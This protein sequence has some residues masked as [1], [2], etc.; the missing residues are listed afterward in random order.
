MEKEEYVVGVRNFRDSLEFY[1]NMP[2]DLRGIRES[3]L[4]AE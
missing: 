3:S 4:E 1:R 2:L